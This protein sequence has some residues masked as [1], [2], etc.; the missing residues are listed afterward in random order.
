M[1]VYF[2]TSG[3]VPIVIDEPSSEIA[4]RLWDEADRVVSSRLSYAEARAALAM[5]HRVGRLDQDQ[6]RR[7]VRDFEMLHDQLDVVEVTDTLTRDAGELAEAFGLPCYDAV[8][9]ASARALADPE[10][11]LAARDMDLLEAARSLDIATAVLAGD[12]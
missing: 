9:L 1:I 2:D 12:A 7:A 11:V 6:L 5:A 3:L 8:H 4:S 10:L